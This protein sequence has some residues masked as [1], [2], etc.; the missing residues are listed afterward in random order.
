MTQ[1]HHNPD[2]T[3][4]LHWDQYR[5]TA[6]GRYQLRQEQDFVRTVLR[7]APRPP[8][9]LELCSCA[10][11]VTL[12]LKGLTAGVTGLDIDFEALTV[13]KGPAHENPAVVA[14]AQSLPF[15]QASFDC[16]VAFQ[17]FRYFEH[18]AFLTNCN[19]V[20]SNDGWLVFQMV[21]GVSYKRTLRRL[22]GSSPDEAPSGNITADEVLA[23]ANAHG[24]AVKFV[25]GYNWV[26]FIPDTTRF[27]D[28]PAVRIAAIAERMLQLERYYR[29]S[30]WV[31]IAAQK[32][33]SV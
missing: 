22:I 25:K 10:G 19:R 15:E 14:D 6:M 9:L 4:S 27:S 31:L 1:P 28:S 11:R 20:L 16:V 7:A 13:F 30:P 32:V 21:N 5:D 8:K 23:A 3:T 12:P 29:V 26:P 24:F 2:A 17:C 33:R 18:R